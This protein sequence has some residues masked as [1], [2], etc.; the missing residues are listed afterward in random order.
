MIKTVIYFMIYDELMLSRK[1]K[2]RQQN[3]LIGSDGTKIKHTSHGAL[4]ALID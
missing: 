2:I 4:A 1:L 3:F